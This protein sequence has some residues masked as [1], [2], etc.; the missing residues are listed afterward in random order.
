MYDYNY[1][2]RVPI[3]EMNNNRKVGTRPSKFI[4]SGNNVASSYL[5][6]DISLHNPAMGGMVVRRGGKKKSFLKHLGEGV[7]SAVGSVAT[8]V[9]SKIA[10][11]YLSKALANPEAVEGDAVLG[12]EVAETG[13]EAVGEGRR[14][15]GRP[16]KTGGKIKATKVLKSV[17]KV[18]I[19][20]ATK[21]ATKVATK[22][23]EKAITEMLKS[24]A[25]EEMGAGYSGGKRSLKKMVKSVISHPATKAIAK[26]VYDIAVP[27]IKDVSKKLLTEFIKSQMEGSSAEGGKILSVNKIKKMPEQ[28]VAV[29]K[30]GAISGAGC[31]GGATTGGAMSGAG[32]SSRQ[33]IVSKIMKERGVSLPVASA[34][35]KKEGLW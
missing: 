7:G 33:I 22:Y 26:E 24:G 27:I 32:K 20:I 15:R 18:A 2:E 21:V 12:A 29:V 35:V 8:G 16:R 23:L 19:P 25:E 4:Q 11:D 34:I 31:C 17:G 3:V 5:Y 1:S 28:E 6:P 14:K 10:V 13:A 9:G 30:G